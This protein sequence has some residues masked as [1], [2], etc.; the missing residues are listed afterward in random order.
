MKKTGKIVFI[1]AEI[2]L[3]CISLAGK[4]VY[5]DEVRYTGIVL[6]FVYAFLCICVMKKWSCKECLI[7]TGLFFTCIADY[8]L[9]IWNEYFTIGVAFFLVT[10]CFYFFYL[11]WCF[12]AN[13]KVKLIIVKGF[14]AIVLFLIASGVMKEMVPL[15]LLLTFYIVVFVGNIVL[16]FQQFQEERLFAI[17]LVLFFCCD[18]CVGLTNANLFFTGLPCYKIFDWLIWL[19]YLPSQVCIS[20]SI[21]KNRA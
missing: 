7:L 21:S 16:G 19:F 17:G 8:F 3:Y 4:A 6:C 12:P 1:L 13:R 18:I 9:V 14:I 15:L 20:Y 10:Q 5:L 11:T 2:I